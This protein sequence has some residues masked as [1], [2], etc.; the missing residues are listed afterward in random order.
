MRGSLLIEIRGRRLEISRMVGII[1]VL[2]KIVIF[3]IGF[4]LAIVNLLQGLINKVQGK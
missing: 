2:L 1:L 4:T 3:F